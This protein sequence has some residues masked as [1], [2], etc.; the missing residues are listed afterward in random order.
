[1]LWVL[2]RW[3][4][5]P[6]QCIWEPCSPARSAGGGEGWPGGLRSRCLGRWRPHLHHV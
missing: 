4:W 6:P 3:G 2:Q 1:M 5:A